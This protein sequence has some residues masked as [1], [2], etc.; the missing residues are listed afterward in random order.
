M[1][2]EGSADDLRRLGFLTE[3]SPQLDALDDPPGLVSLN[4]LSSLRALAAQLSQERSWF[5]SEALDFLNERDL[6][7]EDL[8]SKTSGLVDIGGKSYR[9]AL[10]KVGPAWK[11][12]RPGDTFV[13]YLTHEVFDGVRDAVLAYQNGDEVLLGSAELERAPALALTF[14]ESKDALP[15]E[16]RF[17][18]DEPIRLGPSR[19]ADELVRRM[20][21]EVAPTQ[22]NTS[23][24]AE[25]APTACSATNVPVCPSGYSPYFVLRSL[26]I[27][28][29]HEGSFKGNPEIELFPLRLDSV[30]TSGG[31]DN[32]I[33]DWIFS[34]RSVTD[35][36]GR[37]RYLPNVNQKHT[38]YNISNG[39]AIFPNDTGQEWS[40]TLVEQDDNEGELKI[41]RTKINVTKLYKRVTQIV[42]DIREAQYFH[43]LR[44]VVRLLLDII[45]I[46]NDGDDIYQESL[47]ISN[48]LFCGDGLGQP[49]PRIFLLESS[50]W[51]MQG[52]YA[53]VNPACP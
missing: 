2:L 39:L 5:T 44:G 49:F 48:E 8:F 20:R 31:N 35:L 28:T 23:C 22:L 33:T 17:Q 10:E 27:K 45:K 14:V 38:W 36:A 34:G 18:L 30:S 47:G 40:A 42:N 4:Q 26:L 21:P 19:P 16:A 41:K 46:F 3:S 43:L 53:C 24:G 1:R 52:Y 6:T 50:E 12:F 11:N 25:V 29:D 37:S 13:I 7:L 15:D 9:I 32:A 51:A